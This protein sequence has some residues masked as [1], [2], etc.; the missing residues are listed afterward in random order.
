MENFSRRWCSR[1]FPLKL[2]HYSLQTVIHQIPRTRMFFLDQSNCN[3][4]GCILLTVWFDPGDTNSIRMFILH[5]SEN[6]RD[7][8]GI[9]TWDPAEIHVSPR[10]LGL[11]FIAQ[12]G[13]GLREMIK[14]CHY[15]GGA[16]DTGKR[17]K[18]SFVSLPLNNGIHPANNI[19]ITSRMITEI[20]TS[21]FIFC[22]LFIINK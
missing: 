11:K 17:Y 1:A 22:Q 3:R 12:G 9:S 6:I 19:E 5:F 7:T 21:F 10:K 16:S 13:Y 14:C 2:L 18:F 15:P 20:I 8:W 4:H